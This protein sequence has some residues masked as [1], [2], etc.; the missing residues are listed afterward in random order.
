LTERSRSWKRSKNS[1]VKVGGEILVLVEDRLH[2]RGVELAVAYT[3]FSRG[4]GGPRH[5][6]VQGRVLGR[7]KL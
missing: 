5:E 3:T 2:R 7:E 4:G 1:I 6:R